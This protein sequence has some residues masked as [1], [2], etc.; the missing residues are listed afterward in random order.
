[1]ATTCRCGKP[2]GSG[3]TFC[4][5]DYKRLP[6]SLQRRLYNH[7]GDG[8]EEAYAEAVRILEPRGVCKKCG[9]TD[10]HACPGGCSW[11]NKERTLCSACVKKESA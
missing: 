7:V 6:T 11:T 3:K 10:E 5:S 2:K 8:Y 1:M 4:F 9:C